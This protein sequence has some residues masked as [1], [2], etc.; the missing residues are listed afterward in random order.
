MYYNLPPL[1]TSLHLFMDAA[2]MPTRVLQVFRRTACRRVAGIAALG[3]TDGCSF[4]YVPF[5]EDDRSSRLISMPMLT[6]ATVPT[7]LCQRKAID[8]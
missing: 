3:R 6:T 1:S 4:C 8:E 5:G 2:A 7:T